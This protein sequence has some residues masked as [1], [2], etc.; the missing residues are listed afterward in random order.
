MYK[1][2]VLI[3]LVVLLSTLVAAQDEDKD[4]RRV[5]FFGGFSFLGTA[6]EESGAPLIRFGGL[7]GF[8]VAATGYITKRFGITGDFSA[9]FRRDTENVTG[10][11]VRLKSNNFSYLAGPQFKFTNKTR[12][13]P[14]VRALA[15]GSTNR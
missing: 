13:T 1:I 6:D 9:H 11:T 14:F 10:G 2:P 7:D 5:E 8:N 12:F 3:L 4:K 15:G